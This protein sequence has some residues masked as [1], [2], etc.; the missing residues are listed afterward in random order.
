MVLVEYFRVRVY[1]CTFHF[2]EPAVVA[3]R[4]GKKKLLIIGVPIINY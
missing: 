3:F 2:P 1:F 4:C